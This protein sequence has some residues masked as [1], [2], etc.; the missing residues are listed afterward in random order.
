[1]LGAEAAL[2]VCPR[3]AQGFGLAQWERTPTPATRSEANCPEH[4]AILVN[5]KTVLSDG[6]KSFF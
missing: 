4:A 5:K 3:N 6:S 2:L 1:M